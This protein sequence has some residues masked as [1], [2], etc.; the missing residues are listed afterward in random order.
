[1]D[2]FVVLFEGFSVG[3]GEGLVGT[4]G[5]D[6]TFFALVVVYLEHVSTEV[7]DFFD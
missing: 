3:G 7:V 4:G 2:D 5:H 6:D 1:M